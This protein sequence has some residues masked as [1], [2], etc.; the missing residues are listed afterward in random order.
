MAPDKCLQLTLLDK[1]VSVNMDSL[2]LKSPVSNL[3]MLL[4]LECKILAM[5]DNTSAAAEAIICY[6]QCDMAT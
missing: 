5:M 2:F 6:C 1:F 4:R 3:W